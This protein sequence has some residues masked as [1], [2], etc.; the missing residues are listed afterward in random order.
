MSEDSLDKEDLGTAS[1]SSGNTPDFTAPDHKDTMAAA[2]QNAQESIGVKKESMGQRL[3]A[4]FEKILDR[5][6]ILKRRKAESGMDSFMVE[7]TIERG[8][9]GLKSSP[10]ADNAL[11]AAARKHIA[12]MGSS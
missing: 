11:M 2:L 1:D 7:D 9:E 6:H 10:D 12:Q 8:G 5:L 3:M 4:V